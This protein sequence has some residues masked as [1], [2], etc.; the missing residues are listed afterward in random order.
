M[1]SQTHR[2]RKLPR[3]SEYYDRLVDPYMALAFTLRWLAGAQRWNLMYMF[4]VA[5][6]TL[7]VWIWRVSHA[8]IYAISLEFHSRLLCL[9]R[10][11]NPTHCLVQELITSWRN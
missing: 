9:V 8:I 7:H 5:D 3:N 11:M 4:N 2:K 10:E 6:T 1:A